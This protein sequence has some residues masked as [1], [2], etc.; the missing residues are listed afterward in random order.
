MYNNKFVL[1]YI[2]LFIVIVFNRCFK[3]YLENFYKNKVVYILNKKHK[4]NFFFQ[5][6]VCLIVS[7]FI[8]FSTF[9][10]LEM[11]A[12]EYLL[13]MILKDFLS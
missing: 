3:I 1:S 12:F 6:L 8:K 2:N 7:L 5:I 10:L 4:K 9:Y 11:P 13:N